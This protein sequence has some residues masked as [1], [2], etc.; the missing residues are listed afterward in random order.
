MFTKGNKLSNGRP[1]GSQ[2]KTTTQTKEFI[3]NICAELEMTIIED[4]QVLQPIERVKIWMSLQEY[5]IPKLTRQQIDA[6]DNDINITIKHLQPDYSKLTL[7]EL[8]VLE[9][10]L[11]KAGI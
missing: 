4:I 5:L 1:A 7:D 8:K 6:A 9:Q 10:L 3:L 11:S 2:N